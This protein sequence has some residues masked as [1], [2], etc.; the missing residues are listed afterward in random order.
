MNRCADREPIA[1]RPVSPYAASLSTLPYASSHTLEIRAAAPNAR[2]RGIFT[3]CSP[4]L[5]R[6]AHCAYREFRPHQPASLWHANRRS[7]RCIDAFSL[8]ASTSES[9]D[10][11]S[12]PR[13]VVECPQVQGVRVARECGFGSTRVWS[14]RSRRSGISAPGR[15][16]SMQLACSG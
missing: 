15:Q 3:F 12:L 9:K 8:L 4:G 11:Q 6:L 10:W 7:R 16:T 1:V 2:Y 14:G 13:P 5:S